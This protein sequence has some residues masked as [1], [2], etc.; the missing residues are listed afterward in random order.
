MH[1]DVL[2]F[3]QAHTLLCKCKHLWAFPIHPL[4]HTPSH[5]PTPSCPPTPPPP[6]SLYTHP[7]TPPSP[8]Y[9][10]ALA[11]PGVDRLLTASDIPGVNI[12][13]SSL[14][15]IDQ[16]PLFAVDR[17]CYHGQPV[18]MVLAESQSI[19]QRAAK[20]VKVNIIKETPVLD[21]D[22]A[23]AQ[24]LVHDLCMLCMMCV[25]WC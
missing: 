24:G 21:I 2:L 17:V 4:S 12:V 18:A 9:T 3:Y 16:E 6:P 10:Q 13:G 11:L 23:K 1:G 20:M 15:P 14:L 25:C 5:P 7:A 22:A 8:C 19:A